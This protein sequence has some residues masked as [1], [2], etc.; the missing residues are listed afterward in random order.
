MLLST[1]MTLRLVDVKS[2]VKI[3][4]IRY[5]LALHIPQKNYVYTQNGYPVPTKYMFHF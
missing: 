2:S 5:F 3:E 4:A 1:F